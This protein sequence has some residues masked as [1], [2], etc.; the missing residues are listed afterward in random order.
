[1]SLH[2]AV[3]K[4][5]GLECRLTVTTPVDGLQKKVDDRLKEYAKTVRLPGFRPISA[6]R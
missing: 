1:M 6:A 4:L 3:E 5:E 2:V